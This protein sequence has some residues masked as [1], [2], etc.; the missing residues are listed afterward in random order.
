MK[1]IICLIIPFTLF[2]GQVTL[3][4]VLV[5]D[6]FKK[7]IYVTSH[8]EDSK[9]LYVI[10]QAGRIML[11]E[12]G[13]R[14]KRAFLDIRAEVVTPNRPGDE[15]LRPPERAA[16]ERR[17]VGAHELGQ[18][19]CHRGDGAGG[20]LRGSGLERGDGLQ[21][22]PVPGLPVVLEPCQT[23]GSTITCGRCPESRSKPRTSSS[24]FP[25]EFNKSICAGAPA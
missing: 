3:S 17:R 19:G 21:R 18:G 10:E 7:P 1:K 12:K 15:R 6:G 2:A 16:H 23:P 11:I 9:L 20:S 25:A 13:K 4:S 22:G 8:P 5:S 14:L 24:V